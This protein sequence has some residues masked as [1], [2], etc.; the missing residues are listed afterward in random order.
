[1]KKPNVSVLKKYLN[2]MGKIKAKYITSERL[3]RVIG[4]Y[5]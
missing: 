5:P 1:M 2:A 4:V 3:S